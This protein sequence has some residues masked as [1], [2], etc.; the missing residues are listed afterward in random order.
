MRLDHGGDLG[1]PPDERREEGVLLLL[2]L[3][4]VAGRSFK[5]EAPEEGAAPAW[6]EERVGDG[7]LLARIRS[8]VDGVGRRGIRHWQ[9]VDGERRLVMGGRQ[10]LERDGRLRGGVRVP[11]G[12]V[13][14][15]R[16]C[17]RREHLRAR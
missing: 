3:L 4:L 11:S 17:A 1:A 16:L 5:E 10:R 12:R 7:R 15:R 2:L 14:R 6:R 9:H 8:R 13:G